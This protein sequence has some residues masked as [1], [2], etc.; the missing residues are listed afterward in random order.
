M[1]ESV[2]DRSDLCTTPHDS[3]RRALPGLRLCGSCRDHLE[4]NIAALP[5]LYEQLAEELGTT[6]SARGL[7]VSGSSSEPLPINPAIADHRDQIQH[8]LVWWAIYVAGE[9][10][11]STP[12]RG[13]PAAVADWLGRHIEWIAGNQA[14][15][16]ECPAVMRELAGRARSLLNPEHMLHTGERCR[17]VSGE[18]RCDGV[19]R[20]VQGHDDAWVARCTACGPQATEPYLHGKVAGRWVTLERVQ[21]YALGQFGIRATAATVRSWAMRERIEQTEQHGRVWYDL[22]SIQRYLSERGKV[23]S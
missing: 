16:E 19:I 3:D 11:I 9:R 17:V 6:T 21:A 4:D 22:G 23:A 7:A 5:G 12:E 10:N 1:E 15:A 13:T 14:A 8:D 20:F 2:T 18:E